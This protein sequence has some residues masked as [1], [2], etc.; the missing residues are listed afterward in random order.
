MEPKNNALLRS[1]SGGIFMIRYS[2]FNKLSR[3]TDW[4]YPCA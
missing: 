1:A 4:L 3:D 2:L